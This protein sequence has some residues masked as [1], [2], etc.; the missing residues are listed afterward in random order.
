MCG[1]GKFMQLWKEKDNPACP[2][3]GR[4]EDATHVWLCQGEG[5]SE[6]WDQSL[7]R[8]KNWLQDSKMDPDLQEVILNYLNGWRYGTT[9]DL[10]IPYGLNQLIDQ[11]NAIGWKSFLE[12]WTGS[13]WEATQQAH[14]NLIRSRKSGKRWV[15]SL[16]K[17]MWEVAWDLW[18]HRNSILH[19]KEN[20][21]S[22]ESI[23]TLNRKIRSQFIQL[24]ADNLDLDQ[25]LLRIPLVQL[26]EKATFGKG[27]RI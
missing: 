16:I 26:L 7:E 12:G 22:D 24:Q 20:A 3:C 25:Y 18:E 27:Y 1:V 21:V 17:K 11:Q 19:N 4:F 13:E 2:R 5:A 23:R 15:I 6:V 9:D 8:L 14:Y 10:P